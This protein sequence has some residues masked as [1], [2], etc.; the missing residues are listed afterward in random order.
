[1]VKHM[2][3]SCLHKKNNRKTVQWN[4]RVLRERPL[5]LLIKMK[6][7]IYVCV[8]ERERET[9]VKLDRCYATFG[10]LWDF[11]GH[12]KASLNEFSELV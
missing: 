1:M 10:R 3:S 9:V 12:V 8:T 7:S 11:L 4:A 6:K 5:T 2:S